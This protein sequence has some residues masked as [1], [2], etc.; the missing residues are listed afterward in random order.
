MFGELLERD[1]VQA[2]IASETDRVLTGV[3]HLVLVRGATGTGRTAVLEA[4]AAHAAHRGLRVRHVRCSQEDM[5]VPFAAIRPLLEDADVGADDSEDVDGYAEGHRDAGHDPRDGDSAARLWRRLRAR[6]AAH[7]LMIG[8]DDVHLADAASRR[9]LVD[10]AR[11]LDGMPVLLVVTERSQYDLSP[12]LVGLAHALSPSLVRAHTLAPLSDDASA[13]LVRAAVPAAP[14]RWT[15]ECVRAGAGNPLL[16]RALLDDL[17]QTPLGSVPQI[18]AALYPGAFPAAVAWWLDSAGTTT[19]ELARTLAVLERT[20]PECAVD[21]PAELL[22]EASRSD[23]ART[24]GWLTAMHRLGLLRPDDAGHVRYAHPLLRDA[25][26]AGWPARARA[27]AGRAVAEAMLRRGDRAEAIAR[28]LLGVE[29][30]G[31][32]WVLRVL[33]DAVADAVRDDRHDDAR[34]YLRRALREP[35]SD[36]QRQPLMTE[37]GSL[38]HLCADS[39]AGVRRL[40]EAQHFP[41]EPRDQ[42]RTALAL[43]AALAQR[44][45][46]QQAVRVL[47]RTER[48]L[49]ADPLIVR[50]LRTAAVLLSERDQDAHLEAYRQLRETAGDDPEAVG[51]AGRAVLVLSEARSG[52]ISAAGATAQLRELL[53]GPVDALEEPFLLGT[54]AT[55]A[56][57]ADELEEAESLV[58]RGLA[59]QSAVLLHPVRQTLLDIRADLVAAHGDHAGLLAGCTERPSPEPPAQPSPALPTPARRAEPAHAAARVLRALVETGRLTEARQL[60]ERFTPDPALDSA[61]IGRFLYA[62]GTLRSAL[63][64]VAG[65]LHDF[66]ECGRRH[67]ARDEVNPALSPWRTAATECLLSLGDRPRA[68]ALAHE[69]VRLAR[70]WNTPR[71]LGRAM[72]GLASTA[73]GKHALAFADESVELLR[74]SPDRGDLVAALLDRGHRLTRA[75]QRNLA[76]QSLHEA[77]EQAERLGADR[78]R[79]AA[80]T[81]LRAVGARRITVALTG[82]AS[83][84]LSERRIAELAAGGRTNTEISNVLS[85]ARRTVETHL[86][87]TY[88][89][90]GIQGRGELQAALSTTGHPA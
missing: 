85:V 84:T 90:L 43:G 44:G 72:R 60:A 80:E 78:L 66:L 18:C 79:L 16:L 3:G 75:G 34:R 50:T 28:Q 63:G 53:A 14:E 23:P 13:A 56:L 41:A 6:A 12:Q 55:V 15:A 64:D 47:R 11:Y 83:L 10:V 46:V 1:A 87:S 77:A 38:E 86:T 71:T 8:V 52:R 2:L 22:A 26:L 42:V 51:R 20:G 62:R 37:L 30:V 68:V 73:S 45:E 89:K 33:R 67:T 24:G 82:S 31:E 5:T 88:R 32:S 49:A 81:A 35:L 48:E 76:R 59:G 61:E 4:A 39:P 25:V 40:T 58:E 74:L 27:M 70:V 17:G 69:E 54:A 7:P 19:A 36:E 57:W 29:A 65:A 9:W 21:G